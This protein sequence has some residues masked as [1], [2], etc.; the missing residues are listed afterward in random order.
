V[1]LLHWSIWLIL[2]Y[3][4]NSSTSGAETSHT[5]RAQE[6]SS[7]VLCCSCFSIVIA[8]AVW[9]F[10]YHCLSFCPSSFGHHIVCP[11]IY[12]FWLPLW[13]N[14]EGQKD[15]QWYIKHHTARAITIEKH[16]PH[17]TPGLN[18]CALD[19]WEV[20]APLVLLLKKYVSINQID[21]C[22]SS[23]KTPVSNYTGKFTVQQQH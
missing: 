9:C 11:S 16:E 20:S 19:V 7:G 10:I 1:L 21:Q 5:S 6:F 15:K 12:S 14:E 18:F 22:S 17:K 23:T 13:P 8:L 2:T 3:F 4:F